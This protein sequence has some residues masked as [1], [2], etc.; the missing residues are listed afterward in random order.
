[1][2]EMRMIHPVRFDVA[3]ERMRWILAQGKK[4]RPVKDAFDASS[5]LAVLYMVDKETALDAL[6]DREQEA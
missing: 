4:E 2:D 3:V 5:I 6:L 1:M